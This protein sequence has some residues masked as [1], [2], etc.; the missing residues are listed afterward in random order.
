[1]RFCVA[2][3]TCLIA[4]AECYLV[5]RRLFNGLQFRERL[6]TSIRSS[7][8]QPSDC[9]ATGDGIMQIASE[10]KRK[11][12]SNQDSTTT[13][14]SLVQFGDEWSRSP[15]TGVTEGRNALSASHFEKVSGCSAVVDI[16]T[17]ICA[18]NTS[19][20]DGSNRV[21]VEGRADSRVTQGMVAVICQVPCYEPGISVDI[22]KLLMLISAAVVQHFNGGRGFKSRCRGPS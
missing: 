14:R 16:K 10:L 6:I 2:I 11:L 18:T 7:R 19:S 9:V 13:L 12:V 5:H 17:G 4:L 8:G 15:L 22:S 20:N 21:M 3:L 1:M